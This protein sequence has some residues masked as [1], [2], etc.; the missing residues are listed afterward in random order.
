MGVVTGILLI[1]LA[2]I[3]VQNTGVFYQYKQWPDRTWRTHNVRSFYHILGKVN[4]AMMKFLYDSSKP[5]IYDSKIIWKVFLLNQ[6]E[7][8]RLESIIVYIRKNIQRNINTL[9]PPSQKRE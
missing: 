7:F 1:A 3:R 9:L 8:E 4:T 2:I 5:R 6:Y